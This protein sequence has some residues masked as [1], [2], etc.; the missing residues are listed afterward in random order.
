ME[1]SQAD[2]DAP[3]ASDAAIAQAMQDEEDASAAA[4]ISGEVA[5]AGAA[6]S[7]SVPYASPLLPVASADDVHLAEARKKVLRSLDAKI[8]EQ[9]EPTALAAIETALKLATNIVQAPDE[10]KYKKFRANNPSISKKL[11]HC[12]GGTDLLIALG[13]RTK[14]MEFEE[15]WVVDDAGNAPLHMR[16]LAEAV[17]ALERYRELTRTKLERNAKIRREKLANQNEERLRTLQAI[18]EDKALRK[19]RAELRR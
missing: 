5:A 15:F 11:L 2:G 1:I 19:E 16:G 7:A 3:L 18:E 12:P 8:C 13:F 4:A 10:P 14:V 17:Q 6:A 9:D